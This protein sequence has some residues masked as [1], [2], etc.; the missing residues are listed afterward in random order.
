MHNENFKLTIEMDNGLILSQVESRW[1]IEKSLANAAQYIAIFKD[2]IDRLYAKPQAASA[3][4]QNSILF[5]IVCLQIIA[6]LSVWTDF[7]S[8]TDP[9]LLA[10]GGPVKTAF[11]N[12]SNLLSFHSWLPT[13]LVVTIIILSAVG[14]FRRK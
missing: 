14:F 2:Y 11:D 1:N 3:S 6:L 8:I 5:V 10:K 13:F 7:L 12:T 9:A 4:R